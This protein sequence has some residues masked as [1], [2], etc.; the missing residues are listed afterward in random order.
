MKLF[1]ESHELQESHLVGGKGAQLQKL[2]SWK[3]PVPDFFII[4]TDCF[5]SFRQTGVLPSELRSRFKVFFQTYPKIAL[6]SSMISEDQFDS[7]FAGM[8]ET[9]LDVTEKN[10]QESLL[11]IFSSID[12]PRVKEYVVRKKMKVDLQ[13][14]VVAQALIEV[15][16]SGVIFTRSPVVPTSAVAIDAAFGMGEGVVSGHV[17][18]D[19]YQLTRSGELLLKTQKNPREVLSKT[20]I[21]EL[22]NLSLD[23][24]KKSGK[25]S[26]IEWGIKKGKIH[27][28]QLRPITREFSPLT[29]FVDTNLSESYPGVVSPFT[30]GF[31]KKAYENVFKE[32]ALILGVSPERLKKLNPHYEK[33]IS[34]VDDHLY[35]N[36]EH[37]YAVLRAL[38]GGDKN[39]DNWHQMIGG[40]FEGSSIPYHDTR[41]E[42]YEVAVAVCSLL[43]LSR[44]RNKIFSNFLYDLENI[45]AQIESDIKDLKTS[46]ETIF[47]LAQL[48]NRPLGF[49]LPVVNDVFIML[50]LGI[51]TKSL[52][53]KN[54]SPEKL[55]DLL[56]TSDGVD[57]VKPLESFNHLLA[58]ID[59][60][61]ID[62]LRGLNL[63]I[64]FAP[65][66]KA[67]NDLEMAGFR[68]EV[69]TLKEFIHEFGDRSFEELKLESLPLKNNP[70][71]LFQLMMFGKKHG[72]TQRR[73]QDTQIKIHLNFFEKKVL[74]FTRDAIS[75]REAT[76][77]WR[78]R[79]YHLLR[80]LV[81]TL[82]S[83]LLREDPSW[84]RFSVLDFFSLSHVEWL[85]F[86]EGKSSPTQVQDLMKS[87]REWMTKKKNFPELIAWV[88]SETLPELRSEF[89]SETF[90][91][92]Q[93]VSSGI[94]E[95]VALVLDGPDEALCSDMKEFIL[96]TKNTDPAW[97]YIMSRSLGLVSEKGSLL[98]HTA[99]IGRELS[100][101][102]VVGVKQ[103]TQKIKTG[104]RLRID[105]TKG[106]IEIL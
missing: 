104:E 32:S 99:I 54:L 25:P 36:L 100:I 53:K 52:K 67:F 93:G 65:F 85:A 15:E 2:I 68:N 8:F 102:T 31:V 10:W 26:D 79:F 66:D 35:Y 39:I 9:L 80:E 12:A 3:A 1:C 50:G 71:L 83:Q 29:Y 106:T 64:G 48:I 101:P 13:M 57:S 40:R 84:G 56:K 37:Y 87:R 47:Y 82:G 18:V 11:K 45:K 88:E 105:A 30:A 97:V 46:R 81:L 33:L 28:F 76:R 75:H 49:G 58:E 38:P 42:P 61:F 86:A 103:A 59:Q 19:H 91:Q 44:K 70:E 77:L 24:E 6:R 74:S 23:L 16:K 89:F 51:L 78:G 69:K 21:D 34:S 98:S 27:I 55:I 22:L 94:I 5:K 43:K 96:V 92:G 72:Q 41:L 63:K 20:E 90:L 62:K 14:A 60:T 95:G 7:S 17:D 4:T 73:V